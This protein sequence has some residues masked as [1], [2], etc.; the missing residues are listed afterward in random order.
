[1]STM[2]I[3]LGIL[4]S[5]LGLENFSDSAKQVVMTSAAEFN[6][7]QIESHS[8]ISVLEAIDCQPVQ[9]EVLTRP[10]LAKV[11]FVQEPGDFR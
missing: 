3:Y 1:M 4:D 5:N 7:C 9:F 8:I 6:V 10:R 11:S 2:Y